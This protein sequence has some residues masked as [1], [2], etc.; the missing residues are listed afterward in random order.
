MVFH[1]G[2]SVLA[3][4]VVAGGAGCPDEVL[5]RPT[6][7]VSGVICN[8]LTNRT[9]A[10]AT[11]ACTFE[12]EIGELKTRE[13][14]TDANGA[15]LLAGIDE[16][17][18]TLTVT[19]PEIDRSFNIE[20]NNLTQFI[21]SDPACADRPGQPGFGAVAG[22]ICNQHTGETVKDATIV[23]V[24]PDGSTIETQ[25]DPATGEFRLEVPA[26]T[27]VVR[28]QSPNYRKTYVVEVEEGSTAVVEQTTECTLP[29]AG[30]TGFI[31][32]KVCEPGTLDQP[33]V[34]ADVTVRYTGSDGTTYFDGPF[35][36]L[37]D[38]SF[39]LDPI[40]PTVATNVVVKATK[41]DFAFT[42]NVDRVLA[43]V[44]TNGAG[45]DL[46]A[47]VACQPLVPDD[48]RRY[49][50]VQGQYD[51]IEQVLSRMGLENVDLHDGVP[52]ELNWAESLF[53]TQDIINDYDVVFVN[54]GVEELEFARG[55]SGNATRNI[56][57]Y[58]EQGGS[59]YVSD[60][61]YELIEQAFP[62]KIN[63]FGADD[64]HDAAQVAI[65][66][67]YNAR[68][69]DGGLADEV[70]QSMTIDFSFQLGTVISEVA[71][72][73]TIYLETDMQ[74]R[75]EVGDDV[76]ADILP[77]TPVTV[78]FRHGLGK[79]IFTS[80]HQEEDEDLD[81]PEDAVLRYLVFEL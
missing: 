59:L 23:I 36:T 20:V 45:V 57:R 7:E 56:R 61:A 10:D 15:F 41:D 19:S 3:L 42:W 54:C 22:Q 44:D 24:L 62:E 34:G 63:F 71:P 70:G 17:S 76:I 2:R 8:P 16:G 78:G 28:V 46:T 47:D 52:A 81:G 77:D 51:R 69:I 12:N 13:T 55:L 79:V 67:S 9:V 73:V 68:V 80:F 64:E 39:I 11:V 30:S 65:G 53:Q 60:W 1:S 35:V 37:A 29:D 31:T 75:R 72:D 21:L 4:I 5:V 38:G 74:Y 48:D 49:L 32:G 33:L 14:T 6:G 26:G 50:V 66:G 58:V 18:R 27:T 43:R 40:G 25:T